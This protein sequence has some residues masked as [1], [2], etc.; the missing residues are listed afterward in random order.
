VLLN[1]SG[2]LQKLQTPIRFTTKD[3][4]WNEFW[5]A[6]FQWGF[7]TVELMLKKVSN[8]SSVPSDTVQHARPPPSRIEDELTINPKQTVHNLMAWDEKLSK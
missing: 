7:S 2:T 3:N 6:D 4:D 8:F 5:G 1:S